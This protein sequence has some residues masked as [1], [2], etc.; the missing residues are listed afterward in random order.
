[1]HIDFAKR[2]D[3]HNWHMDPIVRSILDT[4]I[5]KIL[6]LQFIWQRWRETK[7]SFGLINRTKT[8]RIADEIDIGQLRAQ[9]DH[10]RTLSLTRKESIWLAGNTFF[11]TTRIFSPEFLAWFETLRMPE[12]QLSV[13]DGQYAL[14]FE[15]LWTHTTLWEIYALS[16][17]NEMRARSAM[18]ALG[19]FEL[20]VMYS[21]AKSRLWG[22]VQRLRDL[23]REMPVKIGD[24][25]TRRRHGHLWQRWCV[26]AL[27]EG[28]GDSFIGTSNVFLAMEL[29]VE[30]IGTNAHELPMVYAAL[31]NSDEDL[32][33]SPYRVLDDWEATYQGNL[34]VMLPDTYGSTRFFE[35][36][37]ARYASWRGFRP[38]SKPPIE[39]TQEGA[40]WF[41][42]HGQD[43][44]GKISILS[45]GMDVDT[46]V[47]SARA[48]RDTMG[49]SVGWG[50]NLTN[51]F[52]GCGP[53]AIKGRL[54]AISLVC[55]VTDAD[56]R[57]A[58]K[59]SDN[60]EKATGPRSEIERYK[61]VFGV[62]GVGTRTVT[63]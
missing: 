14:R 34:L 23:N 2:A 19:R 9:L 33:A 10:V 7:V 31:S 13:E 40:A 50:T 57:P 45:D 27:K 25:G 29:G 21:C 15:G 16:I 35:R 24:F 1:M 48:L 4:D 58:V 39:G 47:E 12:Y 36:L 6:M 30:P 41:A 49:V 17:I 59:L 43:P 20:D 44:L 3:D 60:I 8:V 56:G 42:R 11:G 52:E 38:D 53:D 54:K 37:P 28:L 5:Y 61:R 46:I 51:D 63:V 55:K 22:K 18:A 62:D 32:A 26:E